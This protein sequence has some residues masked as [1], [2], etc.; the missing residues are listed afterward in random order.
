MD[1]KIVHECICCGTPFVRGPGSHSAACS[2][3]CRFWAKVQKT[4]GCWLWTA[5]RNKLGHGM[6]A[7]DGRMVLAHRFAW[8]S[9]HGAI[10]AGMLVCH[11]CD[12]PACVNPTHLFLGSHLDNMRDMYAKGRRQ[13]RSPLGSSH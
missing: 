1:G 2:A 9:A 11:H 7:P 10:P 8:L 4:K 5:R 12:V 3:E 13:T 6:F